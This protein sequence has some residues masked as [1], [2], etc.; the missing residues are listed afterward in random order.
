MSFSFVVSRRVQSPMSSAMLFD[1][2]PRA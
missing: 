1:L 2:G